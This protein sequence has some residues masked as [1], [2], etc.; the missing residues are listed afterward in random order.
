MI[1]SI[2]IISL[3]I[4]TSFVDNHPP[5]MVYNPIPINHEPQIKK[6]PV[7]LFRILLTIHMEAAHTERDIRLVTQVIVNR[8]VVRGF[9]EIVNPTQ[10]SCWKM[11]DEYIL[12]RFSQLTTDRVFTILKILLSTQYKPEIGLYYTRHEIKRVWMKDMEKTVSSKYHQAR[13]IKRGN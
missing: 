4:I 10:F 5:I 1:K 8:I 12:R 7:G 9:D 11:S 2:I 6:H 13:R 3:L